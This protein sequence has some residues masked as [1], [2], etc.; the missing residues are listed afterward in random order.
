MSLDI[1]T[2]AHELHAAGIRVIPV[3]ADG[4]KAPALRAWQQHNTGTADIEEW[5]GGLQPRHTAI[6]AVMGPSSGNLELT[7]IEGPYA[8][9]IAELRDLAHNTGLGELWD[10]INTGWVERSPSGGI[11]WFT[12]ITGMEVPGNT[13]L[14]QAA[15][16]ATIAETRG[17]GGQVVIAPTG[18]HAHHTGQPWDRISGGPARV[19]TLTP[20]EREQ[21]HALLG[22]L[23]APAAQP[24]RRGEY[25]GLLGGLERAHKQRQHAADGELTPGDDFENKTSWAEILQPAGWTI[26]HERGGTTYWTRPGKNAGISATTGHSD[27]KDRLYV[28]SSSTEFPTNEP[29]SKF[30][31]YAHLNHQGNHSEAARHLRATG[32][33]APRAA[34]RSG[35]TATVEAQ[36]P[37]TSTAWND[38]GLRSHQR[39][40]A[41]FAQRA[42][43]QLLYVTGAGWHYW[44]GTRLA[45][46]LREQHAYALCTE[47]L[48]ASWAEA[49][50]D[51]DLQADVKAAMTANGTAGV[52]ALASRIDTIAVH[53]VDADPWLLNCANGTLDL[54][55]LELRPH[56]PKDHITKVTSAAYD[57]TAKSSTWDTFLRSSVPD[58]EVRTFLQRL[59]GLALIG[60]PI[61]HILP[62]AVGKG[63]NGKGVTANAVTNAL[64]DY[65]VTV[66]AEMLVRGRYGAKKSAGEQAQLMRLR[67]ARLAI[68][69]ELNKGDQ[70]DESMMKQLTGGDRISAKWMGKDPIEFAPSHTFLMLTNELPTVA[71]DS[72]AAWARIRAIP[73]DVSFEGRE[74]TTLEERLEA[75][76][77]AVLAWAVEGLRDYQRRGGLDAPK[78]VMARTEAYHADNDPL[79]RFIQDRCIKSPAMSVTRKALTEAYAEWAHDN[80]EANLS[81]RTLVAQVR[82]LPGITE[83]AGRLRSWQG[84]GLAAVLDDD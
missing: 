72:H 15:D 80:G 68:M 48:Q 73:F 78:S 57:P 46:D 41:R 52:L 1:Y 70:M 83:G 59:I 54:H 47:V 79:T 31:A 56:D 82:A 7:E 12:R 64:G 9:K 61:D 24:T 76:A 25:T 18:G 34:K 53:D 32:H 36:Q 77:D 51:K 19:A 67:G 33:G 58:E 30:S 23:A 45:P 22:S 2:T 28:F 42:A 8:G 69:S 55:T 29:I 4:S 17:A 35:N 37:A 49:I 20:E 40:A 10:R 21:F 71:A 50:Y 14:A 75:E 84:L 63:R 44:D 13:K 11:H 6:G 39:I 74:D 26:S 43:G 16:R 3:R 66:P 62:I 65:A 38:S 27:D 5:F 60:R 81:A